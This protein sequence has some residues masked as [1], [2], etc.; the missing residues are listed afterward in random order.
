MHMPLRILLSGSSGFIG[1]QLKVYLQD[2][3][4]EVIC[5]MRGKGD[6]V[7]GAIYWDPLQGL[8]EKEDFEGFD[9]VIHLAGAGIADHRWTKK[10]KEKLFL[11][12]CRDTWLL[13][14][15]LCRLYRPPRIFIGA[16]AIG[17]YGNRGE[18]ELT[19]ESSRGKGFLPDLCEK[20]E[21]ATEA[22]E[23]RGTRVVHTR[24]GVVLSAKGGMLRK[25]L[26]PFRWGLGGKMGSGYQ[27]VSWIAI[28]D[29][30]GA[31]DHCLAKEEL[32]GPVNLVA[33][34][35]VR[36]A[37]FARL[38]AK[39]IGRPA[40]F[41]LPAWFLKLVGGQMAKELLLASQK[42][43]PQKLL[44]TGYSFRCPELKMALDLEITQP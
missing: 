11:T 25:M 33:P 7:E 14:Q 10:Y 29:L 38:L 15:I 17:Y 41:H 24:F 5:L 31:I 3:G 37:E 22:I 42:V 36:Q 6:L 23:N 32:S 4:H 40:F 39:K 1:S 8:V 16:S 12:R 27:F 28:D 20:W 2:Q 34:Q 43:Y 35:P 21:K 18:E 30:L 9:A 26:G 19:E 13:S 44:E